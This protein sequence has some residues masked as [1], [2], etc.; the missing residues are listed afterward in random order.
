MTSVNTNIGANQAMASMAKMNKEM[1]TAIARLSSGLR[2]NSAADDAAGMA[3]ASRMESEIRGL[4]QAMRNS[5]DGQ[6]LVNTAEG[7]QVETVNILQRLRELAVQSANDTNTSL[8]RTFLKAEQ[9]QLVA[10]IDRIANQTTWNGENILDGTFTSKQFQLG[11]DA[12]EDVSLTIASTKS[13]AI[14]NYVL[15]SDAHAIITA[16]S[17][18]GEDLTVVGYLGSAVAAIGAGDSAKD[19]AAAVNADTSS[20]GVTATA[21]TKAKLSGLQ[22]AEAVAFTITGDAAATVSVSISSTSDLQAITSAINAVSGT[23]GITAAQGDDASEVLL[24]HSG[25]EDIKISAFN[26]TTTTTEL[27]L[28]ALDRY[29]ADL[30]TADSMILV[31]TAATPKMP[32]GIVVGQ[33]TL[34]S[35]KEFTVSGDDTTAEDGFFHTIN[36][37]TV[38]GTA[39]IS[40]ISSIDIGTVTGAESAIEAIDGA[41]GFINNQRSELGAVSNRLE[42]AQNNLSNIVTNLKSSQSNIQDADFAS[43][44]SKLTR[45]QILNQAATSML[46][47]ANASKQSVLSLLQG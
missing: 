27:T 2:I 17:I 16:N 1:D 34:T 23:T 40:N 44:T 9:V 47:Q 45:A 15:N 18:D 29:G 12:H 6:N 7:A 41:L 32:A 22:T 3:I 5:A 20:T 35:I 8:D 11:S 4:E 24:T 21:I 31:E 38:G 39:S 46:A 28:E 37:T 42:S 10:E 36:G 30:T 33:M 19:A 14:G 43:E 25:G 13:T 26:T